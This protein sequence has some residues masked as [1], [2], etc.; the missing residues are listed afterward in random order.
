MTLSSSGLGHRPFTAV[1]R[2]R[3]SLGSPLFSGTRKLCH[4]L[5]HHAVSLSI[6]TW[7]LRQATKPLSGRSRVFDKSPRETGKR[8]FC[9]R[10]PPLGTETRPKVSG[11]SHRLFK[12][13]L[14]LNRKGA[15]ALPFPLKGSS[16]MWQ[17]LKGLILTLCLRHG[18]SFRRSRTPLP[19][20]TTACRCLAAPSR[21]STPQRK[22]W[23]SS[24]RRISQKG[25]CR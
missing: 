24:T 12:A 25:G 3:I 4:K 2:V 11:V 16:L 7:P 18:P 20:R 15:Q 1:T 13:L 9:L 23:H 8:D 5:K 21:A 22:R 10:F 17:S 19:R 6:R 14:M